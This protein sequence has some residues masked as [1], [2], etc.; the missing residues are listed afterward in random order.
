MSDKITFKELVE[1]ISANSKQSEQSTNDFIH[2]LANIIET[3][4][5]SGEK[6]SISGFGKFELRWMDERSGRNPQTGEEITVP[7]QNKVVFKPYKSL[8]E[9]VNKPFENVESQV[10]GDET[11]DEQLAPG[12][13]ALSVSA[14]HVPTS[15]GKEKKDD[16]TLSE[17]EADLIIE[18]ESPVE[19]SFHVKKKTKSGHKTVSNQSL[20]GADNGLTS[21]FK[22]KMTDQDNLARN[23]QDNGNFRWSYSAAVIIVLLA[24]FLIEIGRAH[25]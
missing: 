16:A 24:I 15:Q 7:G 23:L 4:L 17:S 13:P 6:I 5:G 2:E 1:K 14:S 9:S 3:S 20:T 22:E 19:S 21:I 8:R 10:I 18:R 12:T 11:D 25:V